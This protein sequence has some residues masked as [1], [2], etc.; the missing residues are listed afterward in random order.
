MGLKRVVDQLIVVPCGSKCSC[1]TYYQ[2]PL[3]FLDRSLHTALPLGQVPAKG[4]GVQGIHHTQDPRL[5]PLWGRAYL[6][7]S[8]SVLDQLSELLDHGDII[9]RFIYSTPS[10]SKMYRGYTVDWDN[11]IPK[12]ATVP[13]ASMPMD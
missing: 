5:G 10:K 6:R 2:A 1:N 9:E 3:A 4:T 13:S 8:H 11:H 12:S 7:H